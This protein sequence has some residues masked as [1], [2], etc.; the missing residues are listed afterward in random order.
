MILY[1]VR[2]LEGDFGPMSNNNITKINL[3]KMDALAGDLGRANSAIQRVLDL[4][5]KVNGPYDDSACEH[6]YIDENIYYNYPCP[7]V[8]ALINPGY[9]I[10]EIY[11]GC[12]ECHSD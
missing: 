1:S 3:M 12:E 6:C 11:G 9:C 7:T 5:K 10:H 4:H 8:Q 2:I